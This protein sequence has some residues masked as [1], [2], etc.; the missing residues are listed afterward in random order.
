MDHFGRRCARAEPG[1][2]S[3]DAPGRR[4]VGAA[5]SAARHNLIYSQ[6][7]YR[8][9]RSITAATLL[10]LLVCIAFAA[11]QPAPP[12]PAPPQPA[13]TEVKIIS[14]PPPQPIEVKVLSTPPAVP[15]EIKIVSQAETASEQI[16]VRETWWIL[17]ANGLLCLITFLS[18]R[19]QGRDMRESIGIAATAASAANTSATA[20]RDS[21]D[22][23]KQQA[24]AQTVREVNRAAHKVMVTATRL[25]SLASEVP[26]ARNHLHVL[27]HQGGMPAEI[28]AETEETLRQ[29]QTAFDNMVSTAGSNAVQFSDLESLSD[30]QLAERLWGLDEQ[31]IRLDALEDSITYELKKYETESM[32]IRQQQT[33]M[34]AAALNAQLTPRPLKNKLGE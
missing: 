9:F 4:T 8:V 15:A 7:G 22:V 2:G 27:M 32:T 14:T 33:A 26:T 16:L 17:G 23:T 10:A 19:S 29:R 11:T 34:R 5:R 18:F 24:R 30:K 31:Q 13:P 28:R 3:F 21:V 6:R 12:Q 20:A 1:R 25:K